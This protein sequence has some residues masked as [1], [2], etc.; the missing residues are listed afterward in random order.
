MKALAHLRDSDPKVAEVLDDA[1]Q[2]K[3]LLVRML[4]EQPP[5]LTED[6]WD[7]VLAESEAE[8]LAWWIALVSLRVSELHTSQVCRA[9]LENAELRNY[10][11]AIG[12]DERAMREL[13]ELADK[14]R[15]GGG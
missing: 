12:R 15:A 6:A 3:R 11:I 5:V 4:A 2:G 13:G 10:A 14:M 9:F 1:A 7:G 8:V